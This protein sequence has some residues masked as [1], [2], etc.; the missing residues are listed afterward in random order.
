MKRLRAHCSNLFA[1]EDG[2]TAIE[3]SLI[4]SLI[5]VV[6]VTSVNSIGD[7]VLALFQK[8]VTALSS[9]GG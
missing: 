6:I 7:S 3:Y 8:V 2:T 1:R 4:A 5:S 9:L